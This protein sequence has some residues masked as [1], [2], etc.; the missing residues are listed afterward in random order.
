MGLPIP[1]PGLFV[2]YSYRRH[3]QHRAGAEEG[4]KTRPCAIVVV[5]SDEDGDTRIYVAPITHSRPNDPHAVE[6]P[7][8]AT[9]LQNHDGIGDADTETRPA[10]ASLQTSTHLA[11]TSSAMRIGSMRT[12]L[13]I[14]PAAGTTSSKSFNEISQ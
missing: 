4:R 2:S 3:D 6:L 10:N 11:S 7:T 5:A 12:A 9:K 14:E 1:A 8:A 13:W